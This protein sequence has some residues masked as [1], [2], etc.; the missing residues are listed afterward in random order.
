MKKPEL[1]PSRLSD[2]VRHSTP[3]EVFREVAVAEP[4]SQEAQPTA[5]PVAVAAPDLP[6]GD[7]ALAK[8]STRLTTDQVAWIKALIKDHR[9]RNPH[10]AMLRKEEIMRFAL[11]YFRE[12]K[13]VH[14]LIAR[15]RK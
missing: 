8:V 7:G 9:A 13:D 2:R 6:V 4:P 12:A 11:D 14:V 10:A 3:A 15:Y 5:A 1:L